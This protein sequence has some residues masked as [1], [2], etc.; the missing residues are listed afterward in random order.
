MDYGSTVWSIVYYI[1]YPIGCISYLILYVLSIITA[2]L[3]HL[4][5]HLLYAC[6]YP[7][8]ILAKFEVCAFEDDSPIEC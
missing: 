5:H 6:W 2:P 3:Q 8:R 7:I 4:M 1:A